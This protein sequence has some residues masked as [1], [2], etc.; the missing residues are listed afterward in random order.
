MDENKNKKSNQLKN[1]TA[2]TSTL[3]NKLHQK[4]RELH[5]ETKVPISKLLDEAVELLIKKREKK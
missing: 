5:K 3:D 2:F 4:L 1:R